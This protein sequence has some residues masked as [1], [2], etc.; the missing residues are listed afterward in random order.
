ML[1][2]EVASF[3]EKLE[4]TTKRLEITSLLVELLK[5]SS[6]EE[7]SSVVYMTHGKLFPDFYP[8]KIGMAEKMV[9]RTLATVCRTDVEKVN[10]MWKATGDIGLLGEK[11]LRTSSSS[12]P[13][14]P[15]SVNEVHS[16][17]VGIT[18]A[19]GT[20]S[21][22]T[23]VRILAELLSSSTPLEARYILRIV[24]GKMRLGVAAMTLVDALASAF[25]T[26]ED[27]ESVERAFNITSD[28]GKVARTLC[29]KGIE[30]LSELKLEINVP[31]RSMLA[32]RLPGLREIL[33]KMGGRTALD[34]KYDGLRM[35]AHIKNG[36]ARLFSRQLEDITEQ[37]PEISHAVPLAFKGRE[38]IVEGECVPVDIN[39]GELLP[40]QVVSRRRGRKH[41]VEEA[42]EE[43]PVTLFLFDMLLSDGHDLMDMPYP[44]RRKKLEQ[45][46]EESDRVKLSTV[47]Y[48][49][50]LR[51]AED[52]FNLA[53][54]S[55]CEGI[56]AKSLSETSVYQAGARGWLWIKY[57]KDY[58][59]EMIDTVDLV[60]VGAF[61]GR[62]RRSGTYGA[63]LMA[64]YNRDDDIFETV[65]KLGSG[66][67]DET[68]F[69]LPGMLKDFQIKTKAP[70]V[71][72]KMIADFW[73]RPGL[74]LEVLGAEI[75]HSPVHTCCWNKIR[76]GS[77][78]AIRFPRFTGNF[79]SDKSALDATTSAEILEMYRMQLKKTKE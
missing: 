76:E 53:L 54:Q 40:F 70:E 61:A 6:C 28:M 4:A 9:I 57:K 27:S 49:E 74:V 33:E 56:V 43:F 78:L 38:G 62:G 59:A 60:V 71:N 47:R 32:E 12:F 65:T 5:K 73:F 25:G 15:L 39:T 13:G 30:G 51:D 11:L 20:G 45:S 34:F 66:F 10:E 55:G 50:N 14:K 35:Q 79:R 26:K 24:V 22:E 58:K 19:T 48:V 7:I 63:L 44:E 42:I 17:L 64:T 3:Y 37:F 23:K 2:R 41:G 36:K 75:T 68:L 16:A 52:F 46:I 8:D 72:S 21:Q 31:V 67:D 77:G 69:G 18:T 29:K 1:Y